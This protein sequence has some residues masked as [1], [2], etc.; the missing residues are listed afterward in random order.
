MKEE[1]QK[2]VS[3]LT[4]EINSCRLEKESTSSYDRYSF[5]YIKVGE[6]EKVRDKLVFILG[7]EY[8]NDKN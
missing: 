3:D 1:L 6:L 2:L 7:K 8:D 4:K 5:L